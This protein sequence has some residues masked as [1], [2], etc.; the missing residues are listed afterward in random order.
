LSLKDFGGIFENTN[1]LKVENLRKSV[2]KGFLTI[3]IKKYFFVPLD[4]CLFELWCW[5]RMEKISWTDHVRNEELL[6]R[7]KEQ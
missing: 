1:L 3:K 7:V 6:L 5:R 4:M 2:L